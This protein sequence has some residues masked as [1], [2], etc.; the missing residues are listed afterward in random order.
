MVE[1]DAA[2]HIVV[3]NNEAVI[4]PPWSIHMG[5]GTAS[6]GFVWAMGGENLDYTDMQILDICQLR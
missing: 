6:Y 2:R 5:A 4:S 3:A 1:P